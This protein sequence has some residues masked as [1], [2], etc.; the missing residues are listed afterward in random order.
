MIRN[1]DRVLVCLS[2]GK[3]S[4]SLLHTLH[5]YQFYSKSK[6]CYHETQPV[7][8]DL[9]DKSELAQPM[10]MAVFYCAQTAML[11]AE[12]IRYNCNKIQLYH[13]VKPAQFFSFSRSSPL[14]HNLVLRL[15][16]LPVPRER[17]CHHWSTSPHPL[18]SPVFEF[19]GYLQTFLS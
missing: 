13:K 16:L 11:A 19:R 17:G 7:M 15:P 6:V 2:G 18:F 10:Q 9:L 8:N 1:G 5:Q 4:L 12:A 3:D 14:H